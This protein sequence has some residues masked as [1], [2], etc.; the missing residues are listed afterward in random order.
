[1]LLICTVVSTQSLSETRMTGYTRIAAGLSEAISPVA[2]RAHASVATA[3]RHC[4]RLMSL[5]EKN[6]KP[7]A[8]IIA[9]AGCAEHR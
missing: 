2:R 3:T 6:L 1:V 5:L 4:Q 9:S 7:P 8:L